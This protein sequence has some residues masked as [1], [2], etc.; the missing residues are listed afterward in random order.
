[1]MKG[2]FFTGN[3]IVNIKESS[4]SPTSRQI[5]LSHSPTTDPQNILTTYPIKSLKIFA[6]LA[7]QIINSI[8]VAQTPTHDSKSSSY[9]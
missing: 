6:Y 4:P 3:R 1:M 5:I 2:T 7:N 8:P 9:A